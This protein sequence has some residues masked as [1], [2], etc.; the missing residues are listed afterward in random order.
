M[1]IND[2]GYAGMSGLIEKVFL[3]TA[4][5]VTAQ[6]VANTPPPC[7]LHGT[8]PDSEKTQPRRKRRKR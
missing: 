5:F 8:L 2:N 1:K 3:E 4:R 6:K 7:I